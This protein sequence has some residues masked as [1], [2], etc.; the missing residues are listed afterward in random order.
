MFIIYQ[1]LRLTVAL[2]I[3]NGEDLKTKMCGRILS[4]PNV[5][6]D[7]RAI[8]IKVNLFKNLKTDLHCI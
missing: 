2:I 8:H 5:E 6:V 4:E 3:I 1:H 7:L